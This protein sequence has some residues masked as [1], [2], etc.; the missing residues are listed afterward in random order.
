MRGTWRL[1]GA[2]AV[3]A[4]AI[5]STAAARTSTVTV[6]PGPEGQA[7]Y[8]AFLSSGSSCVN[9]GRYSRAQIGSS[10]GQV[11]RPLMRFAL[12]TLPSGAQ[13]VKATLSL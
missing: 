1:A 2:A 7:T 13:I 4:L 11:R 12:P 3:T 6:Q 5:T 10:A 8:L 9:W